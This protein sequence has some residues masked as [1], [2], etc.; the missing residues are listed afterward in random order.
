MSD[1]R[2]NYHIYGLQEAQFEDVGLDEDLV[3]VVRIYMIV[4][5]DGTRI[6]DETLVAWSATPL[7]LS[8]RYILSR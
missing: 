6:S 5:G 2:H 3:L 7:T 1:F 8:G 4:L